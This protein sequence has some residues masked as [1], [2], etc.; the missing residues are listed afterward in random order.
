LH[1]MAAW[2]GLDSVIVDRRG[3]FARALAAAIE[4]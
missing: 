1:V 2:L 3:G 4:K